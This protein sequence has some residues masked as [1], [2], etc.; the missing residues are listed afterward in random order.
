LSNIS[1]SITILTGYSNKSIKKTKNRNTTIKVFTALA[2]V[3]LTSWLLKQAHN[4]NNNNNNNNK[5]STD[6]T[7]EVLSPIRDQTDLFYWCPSIE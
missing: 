5:N 3:L 6:T 2:K 7:D 1:S 4:N